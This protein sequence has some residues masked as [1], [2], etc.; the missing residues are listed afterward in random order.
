MAAAQPMNV[1][2]AAA[3][4]PPAPAVSGGAKLEVL[5]R[6]TEPAAPFIPRPL[7]SVPREAPRLAIAPAAPA[8]REVAQAP[9]ASD[10]VAVAPPVR[11]SF[12]CRDAP[13]RARAMVCRD[14]GLAAMDRRM[15]QAYAA[16]VASGASRDD[17]AADQEDWLNV[18][19]DAATY[20]RRAVA[21]IYHQRI[22]E[23]D[24]IAGRR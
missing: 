6:S 1:E 11:A 24:A 2:V 15:K 10:A 20:S 23:L 7:P 13:T 17:L 19:E 4:P 16:A 9:V 22:D 8:P 14:A 18:R 21:D 5:P 3:T 12:D